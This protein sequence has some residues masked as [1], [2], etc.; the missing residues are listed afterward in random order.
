MGSSAADIEA[1]IEEV[2][3]IVEDVVTAPEWQGGLKGM[4]EVGTG[5]RWRLLSSTAW[6]EPTILSATVAGTTSD[7]SDRLLHQPRDVTRPSACIWQESSTLV[8]RRTP[9]LLT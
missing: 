6:N 2:W 5:H 8:G 9:V 3:A 7:P 1:P 4:Q